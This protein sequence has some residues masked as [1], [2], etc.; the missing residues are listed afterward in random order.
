MEAE[1]ADVADAYWRYYRLSTGNREERLAAEELSAARDAIWDTIH[2][3]PMPVIMTLVDELLAHPSAD[4]GYIGAG[5]VEDILNLDGVEDWDEEL[6]RRCRA[7]TAWREAV[8]S[9]IVPDGL[10]LPHLRP[11][12]RTPQPDAQ[13]VP[14]TGKVKRRTGRDS[15]QRRRSHRR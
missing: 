2:Y 9:A 12:L 14:Q 13:Q 11:Y 7:S 10:S 15:G 1:Q 6:A 8:H 4:A 3:P 5:P